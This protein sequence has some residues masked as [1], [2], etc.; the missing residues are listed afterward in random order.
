MKIYT[1]EI[2]YSLSNP[3][4]AFIYVV[5]LCSS[6]QLENRPLLKHSGGASSEIQGRTI[7]KCFGAMKICTIEIPYSLSNPTDVFLCSSHQLESRP[8]HKQ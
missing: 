4:D 1:I 7:N 8:L 2:S 3:M 6:R 5:F